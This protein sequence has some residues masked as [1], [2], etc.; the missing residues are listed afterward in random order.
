MLRYP[1]VHE[2]ERRRDLRRETTFQ[3]LTVL[4]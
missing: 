1:F 3:Q 2:N 4:E